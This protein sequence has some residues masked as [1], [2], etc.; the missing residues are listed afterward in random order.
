M[1][2]GEWDIPQTSDE[3]RARIE[4]IRQKWGKRLLIL[5]HYY[6]KPEILAITD[7]RGDSYAL[8][9]EAAK[10]PDCDAILFCGVHF[11]A[12]TA[13][14]LANAPARQKYRAGRRTDV[15]LPDLDAGC[16]MADMATLAEVEAAW[17]ELGAEIDTHD[18]APIT[19]VNS[20]AAIKAF[21]G[22][23][24]G[25]VCT[26]SNAR[27]I[28]ELAFSEKRRV[29]FLPDQHLGRNTALRLGI[30]PD[31]IVV[32]NT[33]NG[34]LR[35]EL[36]S[37]A[38]AH[39]LLPGELDAALKPIGPY[40]WNDPAMIRAAK[41]ILWSG[42]CP[43]HLRFTPEH[44]RAIRLRHP[45]MNIVVHPECRQ[46]VVAAADDAGSTKA[47][48]DQVTTGPDGSSWGI[49]TERRMVE[50]LRAAFPTKNIL[51]LHPE[52]PQCSTMDQITLAGVCRALVALDAGS[53]FNVVRVEEKIAGDARIALERMLQAR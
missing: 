14:I 26:S 49:G 35:R 18:V 9:A 41:V 19:Y 25:A 47:I 3:Q 24:G 23:H 31:E 16:P 6:Q 50:A 43:V 2:T 39:A 29:F 27:G 8:A 7:A 34:I 53:P 45:N 21:C 5:G 13:D 17:A 51:P 33:S 10:N 37:L 22:K 15:I 40:G 46:E 42:F 38:A 11:M 52:Q 36:E 20:S 48:L 4:Q 1:A 28:L 12:E 44:I 32:W 30:S